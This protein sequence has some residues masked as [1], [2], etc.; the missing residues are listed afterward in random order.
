VRSQKER[1]RGRA[2]APGSQGIESEV[3]QM[4]PK[5]ARRSPSMQAHLRTAE[6]ADLLHVSPKTVSRGARLG[7]LPR[8]RTLGGQRRFPQTA[9]RELAASP[10]QEV[11][12]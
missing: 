2:N 6:V 1:D 7:L 12:G 8:Q 11:Q 10:H 3:P 9:I 4:H 5:G